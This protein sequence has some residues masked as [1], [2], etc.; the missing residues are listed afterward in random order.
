MSAPE[1]APRTGDPGA[2]KTSGL[3]A[4][5]ALTH[6]ASWIC[7]I[8]VAAFLPPGP[9][10]QG[11][12]L[13]GT[14]T[15]SLVALWL[16][17]RIEGGTGVRALLDRVAQ[18]KVA[19]RWYVF[20]LGY[21]AAVKLV[22]A[23]VH[24]GVTGAW[25]RLGDTP[26]FLI[27]FAIAISTPVQ[28]GEEIGWRGFALPRLASRFGLAPASIVLGLIWAV[29]HLPLFFVGW[30]DKHGQSFFVYALQVTALSVAFAWLYARTGGSL[31]LC[32]LFHAAVN[33]TKDIVPSVSPGATSV[34][35]LRASLVAWLTVA[36]LWACAAYFLAWMVRTESQRAG[37]Y[38]MA[39]SAVAA[40]RGP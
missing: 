36:L 8:P 11:L 25:P 7:W 16:T 14:I 22:V 24:R 34:F 26:W 27:P 32:M 5:L 31:L 18:G 39:E 1:F 28:A 15:P 37:R 17:S 9:L 6:L 23:L 30:A 10:S 38:A 4:F 29:W 12:A 33:N 2:A 3:L 19:A 13:L 40:G 20:A 35:H 21:T